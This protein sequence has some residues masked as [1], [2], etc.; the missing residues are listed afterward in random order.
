[1]AVTIEPGF[2][3]SPAILADP[4]LTRVARRPAG[5]QAARGVRRRP[6]H[7]DRRRRAGHRDRTRGARPTQSRRISPPSKP[8]WPPDPA[9]RDRARLSAAGCRTPAARRSAMPRDPCRCL[10]RGT[11]AT[12]ARARAS[13]SEPAPA[14]ATSARRAPPVLRAASARR[15]AGGGGGAA[16]CDDVRAGAAPGWRRRGRLRR[17]GRAGARRGGGGAADCDDAGAPAPAG[18]G[19]S[20]V[21]RGAGGGA[22][23]CSAAGAAAPGSVRGGSSEALV[24]PPL[25]CA[26]RRA[27]SRGP[28][29]GRRSR[30]R[31]QL[32]RRAPQRINANDAAESRLNLLRGARD[33]ASA[34][35]C[36]CRAGVGA[37]TPVPGVAA[38]ACAVG[39]AAACCVRA[40]LTRHRRS[41]R[42]WRP[43]S[44]AAARRRRGLW[45]A[46]PIARFGGR[47]CLRRRLDKFGRRRRRRQRAL[48]RRRRL[49][50]RCDHL[51][52]RHRRGRRRFRR[53]RHP[54]RGDSRRRRRRGHE[55]PRRRRPAA[56]SRTA[57]LPARPVPFR[58]RI[59]PAC[60]TSAPLS[61]AARSPTDRTPSLGRAGAVL[62]TGA[63]AAGVSGVVRR[64][65]L[66][67]SCR[68]RWRR[69]GPV[70]APPSMACAHRSA[71]RQ[72]Y[73]RLPLAASTA[74]FRP[75]SARAARRPCRRRAAMSR[76][77][78][79]VVEAVMSR[80]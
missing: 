40:R 10:G 72:R 29:G 73:R 21:G 42:R 5:P 22:P 33:G 26:P 61:T 6:R 65:G 27:G 59:P 38:G 19:N 68:A 4:A 8:R 44:A 18:G 51:G 56:A 54:G 7:P 35:R 43:G 23:A 49:G 63:R 48:R 80:P 74:S 28:L 71:Q 75:R 1:M 47:R 62:G 31:R 58:A 69:S 30:L 11:P 24:A 57:A 14:P 50:R 66:R 12:A 76:A 25:A 17:R 36:R 20:A 2:Y 79:R 32:G 70:P 64:A 39:A 46:R 55:R 34:V 77:N 16:N 67:P 9:R 37:P 15:G 52:R 60:G 53:R 41:C 13:S 78:R 45:P 3:I